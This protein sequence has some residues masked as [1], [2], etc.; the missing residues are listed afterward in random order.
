MSTA[1]THRK[2]NG[3][4]DPSQDDWK[5]RALAFREN[6]RRTLISPTPPNGD[7]PNGVHIQPVDKPSPSRATSNQEEPK[8]T[9]TDSELKT[10]EAEAPEADKPEESYINSE[11][12]VASL[13]NDNS[14]N[15]A[16]VQTDGASPEAIANGTPQEKPA[17][18]TTSEQKEE[19]Q[20]NQYSSAQETQANATTE[21]NSAPTE[22]EKRDNWFE[23]S[24][25][26]TDTSDLRFFT[27]LMMPY[28]GNI[29]P[30]AQK[31][32]RQITWR[33]TVARTYWRDGKYWFLNDNERWEA[34]QKDDLL[35]I[36]EGTRLF[37][38]LIGDQRTEK[39]WRDAKFKAFIRRIL[40]RNNVSFVG[41]V[42]WP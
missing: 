17:Q 19:R 6:Q 20:E 28:L 21:R 16:Q 25:Q 12:V 40:T 15:G 13:L 39:A 8:E 11:A 41:G 29:S 9:L 14:L 1:P 10:S 2:S 36:L 37:E 31:A 42:S 27:N 7:G 23:W 32:K 5:E 38:N 24:L 4:F 26:E 30:G 33:E 22:W 35:T 18:K 34:Y 3:A